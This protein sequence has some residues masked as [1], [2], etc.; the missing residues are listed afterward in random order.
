MTVAGVRDARE[1]FDSALAIEV[2]RL[3]FVEEKSKLQIARELSISRFRVARL[4][5]TA[6]ATGLVEIKIAALDDYRPQL[7]EQLTS[8]L[9]VEEAVVIAE[10]RDKDLRGLARAAAA[11][12]SARLR[13]GDV[14]GIGWGR[15]V[16]AVVEEL[17][18]LAPPRPVDVVQL[19]GGVPKVES[20]EN[21]IEVA[22]R[23]A[24]LFG[25][26]LYPLHAPAIVESAAVKEA[27][28]REPALADTVAMFPRITVALV[29]IGALGRTR[30]SA[31]YDAGVF[32]AKR[33]RRLEK[34]D[35]CGD[36]FGH[37]FDSRGRILSEFSTSVVGIG[38][39]AVV[40]I[41]TRVAVAGGADKASAI[42]AALTGGLVTA[43]VTDDQAAEAILSS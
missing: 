2:C 7:A 15:T 38:P 25:G 8:T 23:A 36:I 41:P 19:V 4:I 26:S 12:I 3:F 16:R 1:G 35:A 14:L 28:L 22:R 10:S 24:H 37:V 20:A 29:G 5:A 31:L 27:L 21:P 34:Q 18:A 40:D 13:P 32:D 42:H 9:P 39:D 33:L 11:H 30:S 17:E 6:K 43:L